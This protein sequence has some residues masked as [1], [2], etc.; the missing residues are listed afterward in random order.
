MDW[1]S[2]IRPELLAMALSCVI[3]LLANVEWKY[4]SRYRALVNCTPGMFRNLWEQ[5]IDTMDTLQFQVS[6]TRFIALAILGSM[7]W[8]QFM[9]DK[10]HI[11]K[12]S[13]V[14]STAVTLT[15]FAT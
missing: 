13:T 9:D 15:P 1:I 5:S 7:L 6:I 12:S 8:L 3:G 11:E 4:R 10:E 2:H 14:A